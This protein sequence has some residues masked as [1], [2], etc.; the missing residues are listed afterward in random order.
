MGPDN[1]KN[2]LGSKVITQAIAI[3]G[4][5]V[6]PTIVTL[7]V[8]RTNI[9]LRG[10]KGQ[11]SAEITTHALLYVP[12]FRSKVDP[13]LNAESH[14]QG[15]KHIKEDR[16]RNRKASNQM[17]TGSVEL[18]GNPQNLK[19]ESNPE[20]APLQAEQIKTF[21]ENPTEE[22]LLI[23]VA[24]PWMLSWLLGGVMTGLAALYCVGATLAI[25]RFL[26]LSVIP[27]GQAPQTDSN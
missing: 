6:V 11:V 17:A 26:L 18:I 23:T 10:V 14:V 22:P 3:V 1:S 13:L 25:A 27:K 21:I 12:L 16:Q 24:P 8:P 15:S 4:F 7:I 2:S 9:E 5:V 19:V 20:D